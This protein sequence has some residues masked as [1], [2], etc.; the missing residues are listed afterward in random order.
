MDVD[1]FIRRNVAWK[2]LPA[3]I[4]QVCYLSHRIND[5]VMI[6]FR[7]LEILMNMIRKYW[8]IASEI[9]SDLEAI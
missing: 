5:F 7:F 4:K 6:C 9:S 8:N 2:E 3:N 1:G